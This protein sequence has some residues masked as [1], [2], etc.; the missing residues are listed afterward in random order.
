M[1]NSFVYLFNLTLTEKYYGELK[2]SRIIDR[3]PNWNGVG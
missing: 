2:F 3:L 1:P